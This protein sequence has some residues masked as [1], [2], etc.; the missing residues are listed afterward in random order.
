V[1]FRNRQHAEQAKEAMEVCS[2][3]GLQSDARF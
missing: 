2:P 3:A 1:R